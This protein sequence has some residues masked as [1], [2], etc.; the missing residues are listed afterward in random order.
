MFCFLP[1]HVLQITRIPGLDAVRIQSCGASQRSRKI[2]VHAG[3]EV[4]NLAQIMSLRKLHLVSNQQCFQALL[5]SLLGME[6]NGVERGGSLVEKELCDV[7]V[8]LRFLEPAINELPQGV[9]T[10]LHR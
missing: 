4:E 7:E 10:P 9:L 8:I 5:G 6:S 3:D 1:G 2:G